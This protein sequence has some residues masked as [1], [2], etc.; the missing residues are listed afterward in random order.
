VGALRLAG[1]H[2]NSWK[3]NEIAPPV[4]RQLAVASVVKAVNVS[5]CLTDRFKSSP[6][7]EV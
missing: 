6:S 1:R 7:L 4:R 5:A 3:K 2:G